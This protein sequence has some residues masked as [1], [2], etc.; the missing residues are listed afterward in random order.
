MENVVSRC[1]TV[2]TVIDGANGDTPVP[3]VKWTETDTAPDTLPSG[4]TGVMVRV[5]AF[6]LSPCMG[7]MANS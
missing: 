5:M 2:T 6:T 4:A 7:I 1:I 3:A